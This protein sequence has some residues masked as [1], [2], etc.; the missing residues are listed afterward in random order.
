MSAAPLF[1][2]PPHCPN[3]RCPSRGEPTACWR[4]VRAGCFRRLAAPHRI[5]RFRCDHCGRH[6]SEQTFRTS[7]WLKRPELLA[8]LFHDLV[9]CSGFRQIARKHA[10]SPQTVALHAARLGRHAQLF[11]ETLRPKGEI[12]E[13]LCLDGLQSFEFSQYHPTLY[14]VVVGQRSH[15]CYGFTHSEL[16]RS[17][18]MTTRQKR[19]RAELEREFG[20][21]DPRSVE[22]EVARLLAVVA[23]TPQALELHTDE[24]TDYPRALRRLAHLQ[25]THRTLSSRSARTSRNPLFAVNLLDLLVRHS[26]ANHKRETIAF[27]KRR[28]SALSRLWVFVVWRSYVKWFSE[29]RG[30]ETPAMRAAVCAQR[31]SVERILA[32]RLFPWTVTLP[33]CWRD[34]YWGLTPTRRIRQLRAHRARYAV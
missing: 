5:Q 22:R 23:P 12:R 6:F 11:H 19:R 7:Y 31:W 32:Q 17:G 9:G 27:S 13:P 20:R 8:P 10:A 1:E 30:R 25:V 14:H 4:W 3:E 29:R 21:P 33:A 2:R 28:Q 18:R 15:Y 34:A 24:H 16:R 26:G